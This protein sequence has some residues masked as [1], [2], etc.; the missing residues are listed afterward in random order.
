MVVETSDTEGSMLSKGRRMQSRCISSCISY[1]P[2]SEYQYRGINQF[3]ALYTSRIYI[4]ATERSSTMY[5]TIMTTLL[6]AFTS[7]S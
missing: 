6:Y 2:V 3:M 7:Q 5:A 4:S 1:S